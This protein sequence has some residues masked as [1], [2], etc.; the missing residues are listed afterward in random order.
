MRRPT[1]DAWLMIFNF[2][3]RATSCLTKTSSIT[4]I[5]LLYYCF[6]EK[7]DFL[8]KNDDFFKKRKKLTR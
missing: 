5:Q 2:L 7:Y 4:L 1:P 6:E 8:F 3:V